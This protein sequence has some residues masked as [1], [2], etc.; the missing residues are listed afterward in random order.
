MTA[1]GFVFAVIG[2]V[3]FEVAGDPLPG[4]R[5]NVK[6][7]GAILVLAGVALLAA[8]LTGWLW[9]TFP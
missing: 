7:A 9:R 6:T 3:L 8:V 5:D 2:Y 4:W 1:L